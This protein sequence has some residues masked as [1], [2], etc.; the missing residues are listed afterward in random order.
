MLAHFVSIR[1]SN[2]GTELGK[3]IVSQDMVCQPIKIGA[4]VWVGDGARIL[5]GSQIP[6]GCV[7]AAN[8]VVLGKS[9]LEANKIYGGVPVRCLGERKPAAQNQT[10]GVKNQDE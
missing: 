6:D 9:Q 8:A 10:G 7:I 3:T 1:D 5:M 2:H 4:D